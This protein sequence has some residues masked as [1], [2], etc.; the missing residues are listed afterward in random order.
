[1]NFSQYRQK[2]C[3]YSD[4]TKLNF[5]INVL[6]I[7]QLSKKTLRQDIMQLVIIKNELRGNYGAIT[8]NAR[9]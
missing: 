1:M 4:K 5:R 2:Y 3:H 8:S 7:V 6:Q 9:S